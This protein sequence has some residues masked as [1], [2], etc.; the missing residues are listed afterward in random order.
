[1][2]DY[3]TLAYLFKKHYGNGLLG[4]MV[5]CNDKAELQLSNEMFESLHK[6]EILGGCEFEGYAHVCFQTNAI[7]YITCYSIDK[8]K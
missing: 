6:D 1:M 5:N 2:G 3:G 4:I 8:L 7:D